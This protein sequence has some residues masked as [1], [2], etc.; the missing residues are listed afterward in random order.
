MKNE[1]VT[2]HGK[3]MEA[4][5]LE[6]R[7]IMAVNFNLKESK[8]GLPALAQGLAIA[9]YRTA[10]RP[11]TGQ[12]EVLKMALNYLT[13]M[14]EEKKEQRETAKD[15]VPISPLMR[16]TLSPTCDHAPLKALSE[17]YG[18]YASDV[19]VERADS[20]LDKFMLSGSGI[21][22]EAEDGAE[23][24]IRCSACFLLVDIEKIRSG[25]IIKGEE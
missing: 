9:L 22:S 15:F 17:L 12:E 25:E 7:R 6:A 20:L 13:E 19:V 16:A 11:E 5:A 1:K 2:E 18:H 14:T 3:I 8:E 24:F 21:F 10:T 23:R 4:C